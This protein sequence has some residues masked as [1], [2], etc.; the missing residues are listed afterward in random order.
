MHCMYINIHVHVFLLLVAVKFDFPNRSH[1]NLKDSSGVDVE[2][3][4]FDELVRGAAV[5][6][7][8]FTEEPCDT[9]DHSGKKREHPPTLYILHLVH[10]ADSF[11]QSDNLQYVHF[12]SRKRNYNMTCCS[13][14]TANLQDRPLWLCFHDAIDISYRYVSEALFSLLCHHS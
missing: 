2:A 13:C 11:I 3:D 7:K 8:V 10:L 4:V 14:C 5:S 9:E 6:F 12:V 1:V